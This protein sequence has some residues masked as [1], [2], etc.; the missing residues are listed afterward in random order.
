MAAEGNRWNICQEMCSM[1]SSQRVPAV[2]TG[3]GDGFSKTMKHDDTVTVVA[4]PWKS[5]Y[6]N[7]VLCQYSASLKGTDDMWQLIC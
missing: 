3:F 6:K 5:M 2:C 1:S 7:D 4:S